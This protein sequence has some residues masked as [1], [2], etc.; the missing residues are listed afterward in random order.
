[1][2]EKKEPEQIYT[3]RVVNLN[4]SAGKGTITEI[5][6]DSIH[7]MRVGLTVVEE[8]SI[9]F[10]AKSPSVI[11]F[12]SLQG[13]SV[14]DTDM[15][16][17]LSLKASTHNIIYLTTSAGRIK[18]NPGKYDVFY[19]VMPPEM[20][21][22]YFPRGEEVYEQFYDRMNQLDFTILREEHGIINHK[23]LR[24]IEDI[25]HSESTHQ[26]KKI[27]LKAKV[28]ELL[29][30]QL[31]ELCTV[32]SPPPTAKPEFVDKLYEVRN[33]ILEHL[34]E[35]HTL[36]ELVQ[37]AGTN[38]YTLKKEFKELF[39][40][41]VFGFWNDAK[42]EKAQK[43]LAETNTSVK[44]VSEAIGYMNP[45]HFTAAFKKNFGLTP[46]RFRKNHEN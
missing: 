18:C 9:P 44:E 35:N 20:F 42:M 5:K 37:I 16:R 31:G 43:L 29:S 12:F 33:Y 32:C 11:L 26:I 10:M 38:E 23:I 39:G 30:H 25:C 45:Q 40:T 27:F 36:S 7:I 28:I 4:H 21:K 1:M 46:S 6:F 24:V 19:I 15:I 22:D 13:D 8:M 17:S 14:L 34:N 41:T 3:E 2:G